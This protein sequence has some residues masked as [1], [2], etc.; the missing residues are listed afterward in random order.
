MDE[1]WLIAGS[2]QCKF[3]LLTWIF[4]CLVPTSFACTVAV[5]I[6][7]AMHMHMLE[8]LTKYRERRP[9]SARLRQHSRCWYVPRS[10]P[11]IM[12]MSNWSPSFKNRMLC[13]MATNM[14]G[15]HFTTNIKLD[16]DSYLIVINNCC[17]YSMS[18]SLTLWVHWCHAML[19]SKA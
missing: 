1:A 7:C 9:A 13:C 10:T 18:N 14:D 4:F 16:T 3:W 15:S 8:P 17:S 11:Q 19:V 6:G 2:R 12:N 5:L